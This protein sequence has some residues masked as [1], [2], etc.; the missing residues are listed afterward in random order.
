M[1]CVDVTLVKKEDE[2]GTQK[3]KPG[4]KPSTTEPNSKRK[5][6]NRA[7]QRA[8]RER[9]ERYITALETRVKEL[10]EGTDSEKDL[11]KQENQTLK[12]LIQKLETEN[13]YLKGL[14]FTFEGPKLQNLPT[15]T[16]TNANPVRLSSPTDSATSPNAP[17]D[18]HSMNSI[19]QLPSSPESSASSGNNRSKPDVPQINTTTVEDQQADVFNFLPDGGLDLL[20]P[21]TSGALPELLPSPL[22]QSAISS[23][24]TS[25]VVSPTSPSFFQNNST[26]QADSSA[27]NS[28]LP[29]GPVTFGAIPS[30]TTD[31]SNGALSSGVCEFRQADFTTYRTNPII[32]TSTNGTMPFSSTFTNPFVPG[33][34]DE[35]LEELLNMPT[36]QTTQM[37]T[38]SST[39]LNASTSSSTSGST[40]NVGSTSAS[41]DCKEAI[42]MVTPHL[43][44]PSDVIDY[45]P[46]MKPSPNDGATESNWKNQVKS[47]LDA[48]LLDLEDLCEAMTMKATCEE[49]RRYVSERV[50]EKL[51]GVSDSLDMSQ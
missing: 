4:R 15:M 48:N 17:S 51:R 18:S 34:M 22:P 13:Y 45:L 5:A 12:A 14:S 42:H 46:S 25:T 50:Q 40:A 2:T 36:G 19:L 8:F 38:S 27:T 21:T 44:K 32:S 23:A 3:K 28:L 10:E 49:K 29:S 20:S 6:Q 26:E 47:Y 43:Q 11:L 1:V 37:S 31:N 9:K 24:N 16:T 39:T 35:D 7:A 41:V 30:S 33:L